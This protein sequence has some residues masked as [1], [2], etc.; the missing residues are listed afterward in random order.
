V[1]RDIGIGNRAIVPDAC[2]ASKLLP[3]MVDR[4]GH[5]LIYPAMNLFVSWLTGRP[6]HQETVHKRVVNWPL[7]AVTLLR[8]FFVARR[9]R[10]PRVSDLP[11]MSDPG[12]V[13]SRRGGFQFFA[14]KE[15][16]DLMRVIKVA[17]TRHH[18][19]R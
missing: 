12:A 8:S 3:P 19:Q 15:H 10:R 2:V 4:M 17:V 7:Q 18:R 1:S 11:E 16:L 9:N 14:V 6:D 13:G 5:F